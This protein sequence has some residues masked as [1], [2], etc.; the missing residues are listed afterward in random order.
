[1]RCKKA[2]F[3]ILWMFLIAKLSAQDLSEKAT[4]F[5]NTLSPT[6]KENALFAFED[7][8]R[9]N[10]NFVP[11][12]RKGPTF[13]DFDEKQR[14]SALDLLKASLSGEGFKKSREIME[15]EKVLI[16]I[17]NNRLR[18][19]DGSP[20]RDPLNYHF[21]IFGKPSPDGVWGWRFEGHHIS[22]NFTS[23]QGKLLSAT[24][25]F[26]GSNPGIVKIEQQRGK[27][28]LKQESELGFDLVNSLSKDQLKI[29]KFAENAPR[30]ILTGNDR[31]VKKM[32]TTGIS[33]KALTAPQKDLFMRL[34]NVYIGNY[35]FDFS[36]TLRAK[37]A[38]AGLDN[39][40]FA[41][42]GGLREGIAHYYRIQGPTLLIEYDNIQNDANHV[43]TVVRDLTNDFA[44]D[45]LKAHYEQ[46]H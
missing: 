37:I 22:W 41:W 25:S 39:L 19:A 24:P 10:W 43:H 33:Y 38:D 9:Y 5:I 15:L 31:E 36:E 7:S 13:N 29:T 45:V 35:I 46:E 18:M 42:A 11:V 12:S 14:Q 30:E 17:E 27:E 44:E 3:P 34:L 4:A 16:I 2:I 40:H 6:L 20:M 21:C 1:M 8:E 23:G 28:V 26:L 32:E